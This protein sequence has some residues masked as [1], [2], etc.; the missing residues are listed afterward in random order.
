MPQNEPRQTPMTQQVPVAT[1]V[2]TPSDFDWSSPDPTCVSQAVIPAAN[3]SDYIEPRQ[4]PKVETPQ[5]AP[6]QVANNDN[7]NDWAS[8]PVKDQAPAPTFQSK[9]ET[10][11]LGS[12]GKNLCCLVEYILN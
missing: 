3:I 12:N 4:Q 10:Q 6:K 2:N 11:Q 7:F 1:I 5:P 9:P 8:P